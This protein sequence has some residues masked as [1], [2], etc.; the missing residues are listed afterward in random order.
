M[1]TAERRGILL[2]FAAFGLFWGAWSACLPAI[3][4][5][6]GLSDG[7]LGLAL[8]AIA[9]SAVPVMPLAGRFVDRMGPRVALPVV[10]VAF[11]LAVPL[12]ALA[13]SMSG[14]VLAL[15]PL[16]LA[17]GALD[18]V[19]NTATA[20]WERVESDRLMTL[21][22]GAFSVG[23]LAGGAGAGIS[24]E[25]G[26]RALPVLLTVAVVVLATAAAQPSYRAAPLVQQ[27]TGARWSPWLIGIGVLTAGAF[28]C[29]DAIQSWSALHLE[30]GL[31][32][33]PAISG[34][35]PASF[36]GAMAVG[37][38]S[39]GFVKARDT[40]QLATAGS[41]LAVGAVVVALASSPGIALGGLGLAG[42][43]ASVL[44]P[45]LY[46]AVGRRA[47]PG[48]QG[49]DLATVTALGY[50]GF[51]AGPPLIGAV[52]AATS[53]PFALGSLSLVGL[54]LAV[55]GPVLL[56]GKMDR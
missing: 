18:V 9:L 27:R 13:T 22:H 49:S 32:A 5:S 7:R 25:A 43:G 39:G 28:L 53:L 47:A 40:L 12:G 11:A 52:S 42:L 38:L 48:R 31:D 23:V 33:T 37:R 34:L 45:I 41:C 36:A 14:L 24:R 1:R 35:G 19:A 29:E 26:A 44:A 54:V 46:S 21:A 3:R 56:S 10:L 16:G 17:T 20:A 55:L 6:T 4:A 50:V 2:A 15:V 51:V 8:G 30:R